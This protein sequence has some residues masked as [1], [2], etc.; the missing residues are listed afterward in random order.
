ML[1][2]REVKVEMSRAQRISITIFFAFFLLYLI[3]TLNHRRQQ[4]LSQYQPY[5]RYTEHQVIESCRPILA[6]ALPDCSTIHVVACQASAR[7]LTRHDC[8]VWTVEGIDTAS[9]SQADLI[10]DADTGE[11]VEVSRTPPSRSQP[12]FVSAQTAIRNARRW[13]TIL[14]YAED[15]QLAKVPRRIGTIWCIILRSP[16]HQADLKI[17][18]LT[19]ILNDAFVFPS[20]NPGLVIQPAP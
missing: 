5:G 1:Y 11:V 7:T 14:G 20:H 16:N 10:I 13:M 15:W 19:G 8:H 2:V 17:W 18:A 9:D 4:E 6:A 12:H 3:L